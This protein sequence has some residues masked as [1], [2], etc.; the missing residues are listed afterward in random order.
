MSYCRYH[1]AISREDADFMLT[2]GG[3][4]SYLIRESQRAPGQY[5]LAIRSVNRVVYNEEFEFLMIVM[6]YM[7]VFTVVVF[8][9]LVLM[10]IVLY[11]IV[12]TIV[13][14]YTLV[15]RNVVLYTLVIMIGLFLQLSCK[16]TRLFI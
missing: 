5:T 2:I 4:G 16:C 10:V 14:L 3:E 8:Y 12:H 11:T 7:L 1:G 9:S 15:L 6:L 13:M